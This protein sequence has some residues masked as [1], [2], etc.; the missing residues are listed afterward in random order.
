MF[1][2][3][4]VNRPPGDVKIS[5]K[6]STN[7]GRCSPVS[8]KSFLSE[9]PPTPRLQPVAG[10]GPAPNLGAQYKFGTLAVQSAKIRRFHCGL[11]LFQIWTPPSGLPNLDMLISG[12]SPVGNQ[13]RLQSQKSEHPHIPWPQRLSIDADGRPSSDHHG[14]IHPPSL[15]EVSLVSIACLACN[16]PGF[17]RDQAVCVYSLA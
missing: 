1:R 5:S 3:G 12:R 7:L 10:V 13:W 16:G 11:T 15:R 4:F 6:L 14:G 17:R 9:A 8:K 2:Q